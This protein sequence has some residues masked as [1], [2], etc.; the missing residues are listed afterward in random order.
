MLLAPLLALF[1]A[2]APPQL[3]EARALLEGGQAAEAFAKAQEGLE[4]APDSIELLDLA[5]R[6]AGESGAK[7]EALWYAV[8][9]AG[10]IAD[11]AAPTK[12]DKAIADAIAKRMP[13]IDPL[14]GKGSA[15]ID[16][17]AVSIASLGKECASKK[18]YVNAVDLFGRCRGSAASATAEAELAKIYANKKAIQALLDSGL[19]VQVAPK[20][21]RTPEATARE[22]AKHSTWETAHEVKGKQYTIKTDMGLELAESMSFAMEQMNAFYRKVFHVKE[23]GGGQTAQLTIRVYKSRAEFDEG[24]S[25]E[26][27][28]EI[29]PEVRGHIVYAYG[30]VATYDPRSDERPFSAL[31]STLFHES[32]HQFTKM[33]SADLIPAWLNEGTA[34]YFEGARL[35]AGGIVETNLVPEGRLSHL[36]SMLR[37][38][39]STGTGPAKVAAGVPSLRDVV[40]YF[41]PGSYPGEYYPFGWG[42]VYFFLNYE[43]DRSQRVYEKPYQDFMA[44]YKSGG[45]HDVL[46]RFVEHF[47]TKAKQPEVTSFEK[48][49]ARWRK[50]IHELHEL[51]FGPPEVAD[52]LI[53]RARKQMAD[54]ALASAEESYAWALRKRPGDPVASFELAELLASQKRADPAMFR[55]R[56][57]IATL[58]T[59]ADPS[60]AL[61]GANDLTGTDLIEISEKALAKLDPA[62][63]ESM[64]NADASFATSIA[65]TAR[66]YGEQGLPRASLALLDAAQ[67]LYGRADALVALREEIAKTS[68][69]DTRRWRRLPAAGEL[70]E[71]EAASEWKAEDGALAATSDGPAFCTWRA[72]LP[73]RYSLEAT[74]DASG[75]GG[76][77]GFVGV[78]FG[79]N[80]KSLQFVGFTGR[81]VSNYGKLEKGWEPVGPLP[82]IK[83]A[84]MGSIQVRIEV[85]R[86]TAEFFLG[87]KSAGKPKKYDPEDL[88]G[89]IGFVVQGGTARIRDIRLC[90]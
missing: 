70:V 85:F 8:I 50:W 34:S 48:F 31:W 76:E 36:E 4:F 54:K 18:L 90:Y 42:L 3:A 83:K 58:R 52:R 32:S 78:F 7:D 66:E 41:E 75:L 20:R 46:G 51:H 14:A 21:K 13:L 39:E 19:D 38:T 79:E 15:T 25:K 37:Q 33:I 77:S 60:G 28:R 40:T 73:E 62:L 10:E 2:E 64:R 17:Y 72:D 80:S 56:G 89:R 27:G 53:A 43:D 69:A 49:E 65:A 9:A 30:Y 82:S 61:P 44:A 67:K 74:I 88:A 47:V 86:D 29:P 1:L 35:R 84:Q 87:G 6:A 45:K 68:G 81:G 11:L 23:F 63:S 16:G 22:D 59:L 71:W 55:Y 26:L 5:S 57:A 24:E 12:G